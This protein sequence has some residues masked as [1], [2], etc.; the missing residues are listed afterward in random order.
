[1]RCAEFVVCPS[2]YCPC[3]YPRLNW[4]ALV[5]DKGFDR[6]GTLVEVPWNDLALLRA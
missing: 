6:R 1:M 3:F 2:P 5:V 4:E